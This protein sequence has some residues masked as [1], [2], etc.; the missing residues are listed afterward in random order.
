MGGQLYDDLQAHEA[1]HHQTQWLRALVEHVGAALR[2]AVADGCDWEPLWALHYGVALTTPA[3]AAMDE[4]EAALRA[5][6]PEIKDPY[7]T[8]HAEL[9]RTSVLLPPSERSVVSPLALPVPGARPVGAPLVARD[10]YGSRFL[11]AAP[12]GYEA[13]VPDHWYAWDVDAC[14]FLSVVAAGTFGSAEA[15]FGPADGASASA[16][17]ASGDVAQS[18]HL[19]DQ[20]KAFRAWYRKRHPGAPK[21]IGATA[22][23]IM[24]EWGGGQP[25]DEGS[26]YACSPFRVAMTAHL[27]GDNYESAYANRAIRLLPEWV[28]WCTQQSRVPD[29]LAAPSIALARTAARALDTHAAEEQPDPAITT[30]FR[31]RE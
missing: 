15:S 18:D 20:H 26:F 5:E 7:V 4:D 29:E 16:D 12:F 24:A 1:G 13:D 6:L 19:A 8:A 31:H 10:A 23:I 25:V 14:W 17:E 27:I 22:E 28:E 2:A 30:P 3:P 21:G 9:E 11:V